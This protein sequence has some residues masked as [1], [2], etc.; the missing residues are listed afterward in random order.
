MLTQE[1]LDAMQDA[2]DTEVGRYEK[3]FLATRRTLDECIRN[4]AILE[5]TEF[6]S[7]ARDE[8]ANQRLELEARRISL[9]RA[10]IAF[11]ANQNSM[12]PPSAQLVK[13]LTDLAKSATDLTTQRTTATAILKLAT[14]ALT[15]FAAIQ[16]LEGGHGGGPE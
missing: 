10:N 1:E 3:A 5:A 8:V 15:K 2:S 12:T 11:H 13:D 4:L 16:D 9:V 7:D 14:R 6:D